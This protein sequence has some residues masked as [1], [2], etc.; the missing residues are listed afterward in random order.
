MQFELLL[1][2]CEVLDIFFLILGL[3]SLCVTIACDVGLYT[4]GSEHTLFQEMAL[5]DTFVCDDFCFSC[6]FEFSLQLCVDI[7][8]F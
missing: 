4:F 1:I 5:S 7:G 3:S 2:A 6:F 8:P